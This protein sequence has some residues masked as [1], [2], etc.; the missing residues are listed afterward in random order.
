[1]D[2]AIYAFAVVV[3]VNWP[4]NHKAI[5]GEASVVEKLF[6]AVVVPGAGEF[7]GVV[8]RGWGNFWGGILAVILQDDYPGGCLDRIVLCPMVLCLGG[9]GFVEFALKFPSPTVGDFASGQNIAEFGGIEDDFGVDGEVFKADAGDTVVLFED[10][11]GGL[12]GYPFKVGE[13]VYPVLEDLV[14]GGGVVGE[15]ANPGVIELGVLLEFL[16]E[17]T[18]EAGL[19]GGEFVAIGG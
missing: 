19:E 18:P 7:V 5:S 3:A 2:E 17:L 13:L 14:A 9:A 16:E 6:G 11:L 10:F 4:V 15:E 8:G 12:A 1:M